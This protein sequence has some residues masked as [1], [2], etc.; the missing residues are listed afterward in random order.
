MN[1]LLSKTCC[2]CIEDFNSSTETQLFKMDKYLEMY[3][4]VCEDKS[5]SLM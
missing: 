4:K 1:H 2:I 3:I 5:G